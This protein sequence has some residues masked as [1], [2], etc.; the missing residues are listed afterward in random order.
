[1]EYQWL[2]DLQDPK[3][4]EWVR[5]QSERALTEMKSYS[6]FDQFYQEAFALNSSSGRLPCNEIREGYAYDLHTSAQNPLGIWRRCSIAEFKKEDPAWENLL[7]YDQLS[8]ELGDQWNHGSANYSPSGKKVLLNLSHRG[9]DMRWMREFDLTTRKFVAGGFELPPSKSISAWWDEDTIFYGGDEPESRN[10]IGYA[11]TVRLWR[12]GHT[13]RPVLLQGEDSEFGVWVGSRK[14]GDNYSLMFRKMDWDHGKAYLFDGHNVKRLYIPELLSDIVR[15][16][17]DLVF[18]IHQDYGEYA[19]G[20]VFQVNMAEAL[21]GENPKLTPLWSPSQKRIGRE[22]LKFRDKL[23]VVFFENIRTQFECFGKVNGAWKVQ[24]EEL[25]PDF[26]LSNI[27]QDDVT[28]EIYLRVESF[29]VP[30]SLFRWQPGHLEKIK[31]LPQQFMGD[32]IT[33]QFWAK[34]ADGTKVPY[35]IVHKKDFV[36]DGQGPTLLTG[37]GGFNDARTPIYSGLFG[38][39]WLERGGVYV[40]ANIRGGGEFGPSWHLSARK[41]NKQRSYDDFI[42]IAEDLIARKVTQPSRLAIYGRSNGGLLVGAVAMQRPELFAAVLCGVPLLD[43]IRY[44]D[45][46]PGS[47]WV[48][49]YGDPKDALMRAAILKYSPYHNVFHHKVYPPIFF[50]TSTTDDR[51]HPSHARKMAAKMLDLG[52]NCF[53]YEESTG[54][55]KSENNQVLA[56]DAALKFSYLW[57]NL[58]PNS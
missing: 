1:M 27:N 54:G 37:Y 47:S 6:H 24:A 17:E 49:E 58:D 8:K 57:K 28:E 45:H 21:A 53:L 43:M 2:E 40:L 25:P 44:V 16:G 19:G 23:I 34:S 5:T 32:Y 38:K 42:A 7:D 39:L 26:E 10:A 29:A 52:K 3:A 36:F 4:Q 46:P 18:S 31:S 30:P 35:F 13:E 15:F 20:T 9:K 48:D 50:M 11:K 22:F 51:V 14:R 12:R 41:E 56:L 33:N 55:H